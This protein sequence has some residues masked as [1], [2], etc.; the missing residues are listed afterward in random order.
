MCQDELGS[1][2]EFLLEKCFKRESEEMETT[3]NVNKLLLQNLLPG[4]VTDFFIG[5]DV[6]NQVTQ[7]HTYTQMNSH[8]SCVLMRVC[9]CVFQDLY[10]KSCECVCVLFA[11]VPHFFKEFYNESSENKDGLE[12]L[13]LLNEI[14]SDFDEVHMS[15]SIH[16]DEHFIDYLFIFI[17]LV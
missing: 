8:G 14:I 10:S 17:L 3:K 5:K 15:V 6:R 9:V 1:R 2:T 16:S 12:C 11:S 4:H 13:R 7:T